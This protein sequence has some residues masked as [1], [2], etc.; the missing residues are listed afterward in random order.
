[1][2]L[3]KKYICA[4]FRPQKKDSRHLFSAKKLGLDVSGG[5]DWQD[6]SFFSAMSCHSLSI[7]WD[8]CRMISGEYLHKYSDMISMNILIWSSYDLHKCAKCVLRDIPAS[9]RV[10]SKAPP[11]SDTSSFAKVAL[12]L[13]VACPDQPTSFINIPYRICSTRLHYIYIYTKIYC[14]RLYHSKYHTIRYDTTLYTIYSTPTSIKFH[15]HPAVNS[16][17]QRPLQLRSL[18]GWRTSLD[19]LI[20]HSTSQLKMSSAIWAIGW[21]KDDKII[22]ELW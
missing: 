15:Q 19:Y 12:R 22:Y 13:P 5:M 10:Q 7:S 1:M 3:N 18:R 2:W 6:R 20:F 11:T 9:C 14:K 16:R 8:I 21:S 17:T 4:T